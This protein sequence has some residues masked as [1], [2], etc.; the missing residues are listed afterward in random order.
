MYGCVEGSTYHAMVWCCVLAGIAA[1]SIYCCGDDLRVRICDFI[2]FL[3]TPSPSSHAH[4]YHHSANTTG[5]HDA[6]NQRQTPASLDESSGGQEEVTCRPGTP[7]TLAAGQYCQTF[8]P[9]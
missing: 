4:A 2:V 5:D 6:A 8:A 9:R 1:S 7:P 3:G